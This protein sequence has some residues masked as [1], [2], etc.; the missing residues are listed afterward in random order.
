MEDSKNKY[1][2]DK[3]TIVRNNTI[4]KCEAAFGL[5][6]K[7]PMDSVVREGNVLTNNNKTEIMEGRD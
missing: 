3:K 6:P 2:K 1:E 7:F 5:N 4:K